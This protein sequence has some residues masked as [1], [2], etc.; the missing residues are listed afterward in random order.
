M[1]SGYQSKISQH[2]E[3]LGSLQLFLAR[4][5]QALLII[6][7]G[8]SLLSI[9]TFYSGT[10]TFTKAVSGKS[11]TPIS[12]IVFMIKENRSFDSMFGTFPGA[13]GATTYPDPQGKIHPLNHQSDQVWN[14]IDHTHPGYVKAFD[15]GKLDKFSLLGGAIQHGIDEADSQFYQSDIPN[16]WA[17]AKTFGLADKFFST[18][19]GPSFPNH[20]YTIAGEDANVISLPRTG[21]HNP[22]SEWGCDDPKGTTVQQLFP[23]GSIHSAFPCFNFPTLG[24]LLDS[25]KISWKYYVNTNGSPFDTYD[26]IK[27]IRYSQDWTTH[28]SL[29]TNFIQDASSGQ[30]PAVSWLLLPFQYSDHIPHSVCQGENQTVQEINAI[31]GNA[32]LWASTAIFLSWDD[33]GGFYDHVVPPV[34]QNNSLI[35]FGARVPVIII[36]PF[37][38]AGYVDST[39]YSFP[40]QLRFT[41]DVFGLPTLSSLDPNSIDGQAKDMFNAFN[42][43]QKPLPPLILSQRNCPP[44][45]NYATPQDDTD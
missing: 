41:E 14:D 34:G 9:G 12:H 2:W 13:D 32:S 19:S 26:A 6:A 36:S 29:W 24:D 37:A 5:A 38:K 35:Q 44:S 4:S 31:M 18:I 25:A 17:Y 7:V 27:H 42:F 1:V 28:R 16:Y 3:M 45:H 40:S 33:F 11:P 22:S 39:F 10:K 23:D 8:V 15:N 20:L 30:L 21:G 43:F